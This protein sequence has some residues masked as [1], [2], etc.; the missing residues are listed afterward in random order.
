MERL[1]QKGIMR[2]KITEDE[3]ASKLDDQGLSERQRLIKQFTDHN[4]Q[5]LLGMKCLDE[6]I[7]IPNA[8]V[9]F[10]LANSTNP[11]E[12]VQRVGRV[13]RQAPNKPVSE[14]YDFI[15]VHNSDPNLLK[16]E[17]LRALQIAQNAD[18]FAEVRARFA[19]KGVTL[20]AD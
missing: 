16:K 6:G 10:L 17:A 19:E 13:I 7:D 18:N 12:Y 8:R 14:I 5:V 15:T 2:A 9:A 3:S 20:D 4:L 1:A 11:R